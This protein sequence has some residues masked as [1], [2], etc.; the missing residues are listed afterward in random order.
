MAKTICV[1][2]DGVL[3]AYK[4]WFGTDVIDGGPVSGAIEWLETVTADETLTIAIFSSRSCLTSGV[5]AMVKWLLDNGLSREAL[6]KIEFPVHKPAA[7]VSID[8]RCLRF[9][10]QFPNLR[11]LHAFKPW[12]KK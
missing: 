4:E 6:N 8:D 10:G 9:D 2:F 12:W 1:D 7:H 5:S 11:D 3:H